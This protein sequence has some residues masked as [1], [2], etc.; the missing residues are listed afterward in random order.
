MVIS[1]YREAATGTVKLPYVF[2]TVTNLM[3]YNYLLKTGTITYF[4][5]NQTS[6]SAT[7]VTPAG[8]FRYVIIPG[9]VA[10]GRLM[11]GAAAGYSVAELQAMP[12]EQLLQLFK[13]PANG[14]NF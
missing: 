11:Q 12:Y 5:A 2:G 9:G 7:G 3:Q 6:G 1:Y 8:D 10:G 4:V 14:S 13:I